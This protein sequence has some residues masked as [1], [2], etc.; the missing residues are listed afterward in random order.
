[1][2]PFINK[3]N[4]W[5]ITQISLRVPGVHVVPQKT[6]TPVTLFCKYVPVKWEE[7]AQL[8]SLISYSYCSI[9]LF[10]CC[11]CARLSGAEKQKCCREGN[12]AERSQKGKHSQ[13]SGNEEE[14]GEV[15]ERGE[16]NLL[17]LAARTRG[18][19]AGIVTPS[20]SSRQH[21]AFEEPL[22]K[23]KAYKDLR[24]NVTTR[25]CPDPPWPHP[26]KA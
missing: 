7:A 22:Q 1:M 10:S 19:T 23:N 5:K 8:I 11:F 3:T 2:V 14:R 18:K 15:R 17:D 26:G 12:E 20:T 24:G 16:Q 25:D 4:K 21:P 13:N 6:V 9:F